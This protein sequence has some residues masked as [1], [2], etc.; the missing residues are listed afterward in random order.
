MDEY[1]KKIKRGM[2]MGE[3]VNSGSYLSESDSITINLQNVSHIIVSY[4]WD[5][6]NIILEIRI[7][8][9]PSGNIL[10]S[11][12]NKKDEIKAR[13]RGLGIVDKQI[14]II[15]FDMRIEGDDI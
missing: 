13:F 9:T 12:F 2:A 15:S 5:E 11:A 3:L 6:D 7:L 10:T 1:D 14:N 8:D 4:K